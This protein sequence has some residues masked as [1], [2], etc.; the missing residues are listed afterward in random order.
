MSLNSK[1]YASNLKHYGLG[2]LALLLIMAGGAWARWQHIQAGTFHLDE[3]ISMLAIQMILEKGRPVLPSGLYYDHGLIYSYA[4][5]LVTSLVG[6]DPLGAR[7]WSLG[8]GTLNIGFIYLVC[9]RLFGSPGWGLVA[10]LGMAGYDEAIQWGGRVRMYSQAN[11]L[12]LSWIVLIWLGTFGGGHRWAR[13]AFII[14]LWL[15]IYSHLALL[16][17]L[18]PL[19]VALI[20][21]WI[22]SSSGKLNWPELSPALLLEITAA[23]IVV[24]VTILGSRSSFVAGYRVDTTKPAST[25]EVVNTTPADDVLNFTFDLSRWVEM[26]EYL[27]EETLL[28]F[29]LLG[30]VA[31]AKAGLA[32]ARRKFTQADLAALFI[33]LM[34]GAIIGGLLLFVDSRWQV[35]RYNFL[36]IFPLVLLLAP[37][38]LQSAAQ[39]WNWLWRRLLPE[40]SRLSILGDGLILVVLGLFWPLNGLWPSAAAAMRGD[41]DTPNQ[42]NLAFE[43]VDRQRRLEDPLMTIQ[44]AP[45][46]LFSRSLDYYTNQDS[47]LIIPGPEGGWIDGYAGAAYIEDVAGLHDALSRPGRLW[48][49]IDEERLYGHLE[50]IFAQEVLERMALAH[51]IENVVILQERLEVS[52]PAENPAYPLDLTLGNSLKLVGYSLNEPL[53]PGQ[54]NLLHFYLENSRPLWLYKVFVHLRDQNGQVVAQA[55]FTPLDQIDEKLRKRIVGEAG[56]D[57]I[58]LTTNL[59]LNSELPAGLYTLVCGFYE[60]TTGQRVPIPNDTSGENALILKQIRAPLSSK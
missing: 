47:P 44:P 21:V 50:P 18:P 9:W 43:W 13:W 2:W 49:V 22:V 57:R 36:I 10:A 35:S 52:L 59:A 26:G 12:F 32:L 46:Y 39:G 60:P 19:I 7:W 28:P 53:L 6:G 29:S 14:C 38:G 42:F 20:G 37:Y 16:L 41:T 1:F 11:L 23:I 27:G 17:A 51:S 15:G 25:T 34:L 45:A 56:K 5:A 55:D 31:V 58:V 24:V 3:F 33:A 30:L 40:Q 54:P 48:F 4:G 8:V